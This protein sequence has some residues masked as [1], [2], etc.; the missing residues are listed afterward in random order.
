MR[1]FN[2]L[3]VIGQIVLCPFDIPFLRILVSR[4]EQCYRV[5][6]TSEIYPKS[7]PELERRFVDA[8]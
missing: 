1:S 6:G 8:V 2:T 3:L 5:P 7:R 4:T